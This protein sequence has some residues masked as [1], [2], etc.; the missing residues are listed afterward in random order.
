MLLAGKMPGFPGPVLMSLSPLPLG[1][2]V[3][4]LS[5]FTYDM[6]SPC[7]HTV[8]H[9]QPYMLLSGRKHTFWSCMLS[10]NLIS[11]LA[12]FCLL[13]LVL[14]PSLSPPLCLCVPVCC[15]YRSVNDDMP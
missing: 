6:L 5:V 4:L 8:V 12:R 7:A 9:E 13:S 3:P 2:S 10:S 1:P 15:C 11:L 14:S